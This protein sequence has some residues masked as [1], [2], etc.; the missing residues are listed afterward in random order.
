MDIAIVGY[1]DG[2]GSITIQKKY[3]KMIKVKKVALGIVYT[4]FFV[5]KLTAQSVDFVEIRDINHKDTTGLQSQYKLPFPEHYDRMLH[6][7]D[8]KEFFYKSDGLKVKG[9]MAQPKAAGKYPCIIYNRGGIGSFSAFTIPL[10][11]RILGEMASWGYV[12]ITTQ[13]RGNDGSEGTEDFG[14]DDLNDILNLI[15][16]LDKVKNADTSR[17]GMYGRS[18][19]GMKSYL[20]LTRTNKIKAAVIIGA[21][22]DFKRSLDARPALDSTYAAVIPGYR[23]HREELLKQRSMIYW[24]DKMYKGTPI[25]LMHGS[26]DKRVVPEESLMAADAL[27]K[28]RHPF[29]FVFFEGDDHGLSANRDE[30][31]R[32]TQLWYKKYLK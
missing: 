24:P 4:L 26:E 21:F 8:I 3:E 19:G 2:I 25:L 13:L 30:V 11:Q 32:L 7:V 18:T 29:R 1:T 31:N 15:P 23:D 6:K 20:A 14:G 10:V 27:Y 12:V 17:I 9:Y 5:Q 28:S 22:S 16:L